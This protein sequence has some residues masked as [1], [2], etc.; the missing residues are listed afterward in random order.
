MALLQDRQERLWVGTGSGLLSF[1]R[2][3][4]RYTRWPGRGDDPTGLGR[5]EIWDIAEDESGALWV[6]ATD[7]GCTTSTRT[8]VAT[9]ATGTTRG[10]REHQPGAGPPAGCGRPAPALR[11]H[12]ERRAQR[13][14]PGHGPL[15]AP[16]VRPRRRDSLNSSSIW[17]LRFDDQGIL[18][19]GTF[20]G[21]VNYVSPLGQR[22]QHVQA[23]RGGLSD[24][25]VSAVLED[26]R[27]DLWIGTDGG[28][29]N[30]LDRRTGAFR[31]YRSRPRRPDD[32]RLRRRPCAATRTARRTSGS[33][34]GTAGLG[35]LDP[36]T[37]ARHAL[38]SRPDDPT[39]SAPTTSGASWSC[40]AASC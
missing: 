3:S 4:G 39:T 33:A 17:A 27:G 40:A 11:R 36:P 28:G 15:R 26:R 10:T 23:R 21:G 16:S 5:A 35:R 1:D 34:A 14:R 8:P 12:R 6:A 7:G 13:P 25:H 31:Y 9:R 37:R 18:W 22:F 29:L 2:R 20:N 19:I 38:P 24:P 32:A 30:R